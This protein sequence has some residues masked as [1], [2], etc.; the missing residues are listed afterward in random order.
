MNLL[1]FMI[2][3]TLY[4]WL[5]LLTKQQC[6]GVLTS[7]LID[8]FRKWDQ[9]TVSHSQHYQLS[10]LTSSSGISS[11]HSH[12][13]NTYLAFHSQCNWV[14]CSFSSVQSLCR[15]CN[16]VCP[17]VQTA[18]QPLCLMSQW[19]ARS[20]TILLFG[21]LV[22]EGK[23]C[24]VASKIMFHFGSSWVPMIGER[25]LVVQTRW[26]SN[27]A[28]LQCAQGSRSIYLVCGKVSLFIFKTNVPILSQQY[29]CDIQHL[30]CLFYSFIGNC[31]HAIKGSA[32]LLLSICYLL[33]NAH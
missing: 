10:R 21:M 16:Q 29:G 1:H 5:I 27:C 19:L 8:V 32:T 31:L 4:G 12:I 15:S 25:A 11:L 30:Q 6:A 24:H 2:M 28:I 26:G 13:D 7:L 14:M 9:W 20:T 23:W 3:Q 18:I 22:C 33:V 17:F